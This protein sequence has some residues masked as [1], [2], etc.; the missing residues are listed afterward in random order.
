MNKAR[1]AFYFILLATI[2]FIF[3]YH[4]NHINKRNKELLTILNLPLKNILSDDATLKVSSK[5]QIFLIEAHMNKERSLDN[6][7]QACSVESAGSVHF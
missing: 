3:L 2:I 5:H 4:G 1:K 6:A 7:R